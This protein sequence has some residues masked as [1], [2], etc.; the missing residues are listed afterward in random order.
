MRNTL[1][2]AQNLAG[3]ASLCAFLI[4]SAAGFLK[5]E[6]YAATPENYKELLPQL[7]PGDTLSLASGEYPRLALTDLRGKPNAWITVTGPASDAPAVI[8]GDSAA[9][10]VEIWN[11]SYV[12]IENLRI[13]SRGI[14][15][16]FGVS[17][18]GGSDNSTHHIRLEGNTFVGQDGGQQ[19]D[20]ISTKIPTW[21]W[22]IR[23]N[24]I[25]GA[26]TGMYLGNSDG[27]D[28]FVAGV[29]ENNLIRDTIGYNIE[30]KDQLEIP[31]LHGMP[32]APTVTII[33]NNVFVKND[34][35]S[36]D[37]DRPNLLVGAFPATGLESLDMYEIYGNLFVHNPREA[38]FQGSGRV[39]LHDNVFI[40][41]CPRYPAV[42]LTKH[43]KPLQMAHVYNNT[44]Y[45]MGQ[46]IR[47]GSDAEQSDAVVGNLVF[48]G[49]KPLEGP[50]RILADNIT[51]ALDTAR[52]FVKAPSLDPSK[53][54][55]YPLPGKCQ[56]API[57][58]AMFQSGT[59]YTLDFNGRSKVQEKGQ[60]IY[61][62]AYAGEGESTGWHLQMAVKAPYPPLPRFPRLI[63][64]SPGTQSAGQIEVVVTGANFTNG[65][66]V[67]VSGEGIQV[68]KT[69]VD[70]E[71]QI[72]ATLAVTA[73]A[74]VDHGL[75]VTTSL[76][77][78]NVMM[79]HFGA[80]D[81]N[82]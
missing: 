50:I 80:S 31:A 57:N 4:C 23:Y 2:L 30:I 7:K 36:P 17:A 46:G 72:T 75:V 6:V 52:A 48:S 40:D 56:G 66:T 51:A 42:V 16:A 25:L 21:E 38:L 62:G 79:L 10:T 41:G 20:A 43:N 65:S 47:F 5:A 77:G 22:V 67:T 15:G 18:K 29:I 81:R 68:A 9:N 70:S 44:I 1:R 14:P 12:A 26:G 13:D 49:S 69:V 28:P 32:Q 82:P 71:T 78:S 54:D 59:D 37:G 63:W 3:P 34:R 39:V 45:T 24:K 60:V 8:V 27:T 19:T 35:P 61:R 74:A 73:N 55:F 53:A 58:L 64:V 11:C 33:R 76:G